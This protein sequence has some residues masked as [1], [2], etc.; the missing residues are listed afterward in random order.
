MKRGKPESTAKGKRGVGSLV[1]L[2]GDKVRMDFEDGTE[3]GVVIS[4]ET[5]P[6]ILRKVLAKAP[7]NAKI[8]V[9]ITFDEAQTKIMFVKPLTG[10]YDFKFIKFWAAEGA[11][12][13]IE[14]KEGKGKKPYGQFSASLEIQKKTGSKFDLWNGCRF[15]VFFFDSFGKDEDGN[16]LVLSKG[17]SSDFLND[18]MD[19]I[20]A[21]SQTIPYSENPLPA[22]EEIA[23]A[24]GRI[25]SCDVR[26]TVSKKD[27]QSYANVVMFN[28][29]VD[30]DFETA[31]PESSPE[32]E[33][34][35]AQK[36]NVTSHPALEE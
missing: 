26:K 12:P 18:F 11:K 17:E 22:I 5:V 24:E 2:A 31:F 21:G 30:E 20:G 13:T 8:N 29:Y 4:E 23:L 7:D 14:I 27:G 15:S 32:P 6:E 25:F 28:T 19:V 9:D 34:T 3:I 36:A 33:L 10:T 35:E 16:L 1:K